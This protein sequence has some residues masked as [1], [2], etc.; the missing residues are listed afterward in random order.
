MGNDCR[1]DKGGVIFTLLLTVA[2]VCYLRCHKYQHINIPYGEDVGKI[3]DCPSLV[4]FDDAL[5]TLRL[6][7]LESISKQVAEC[8]QLC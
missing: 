8:R 3:R 7:F 5:D 1:S 6:V 2:Q 4:C